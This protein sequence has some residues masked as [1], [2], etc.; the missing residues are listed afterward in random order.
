VRPRLA[1]IFAGL[2]LAP[3]SL[4]VWIG[5]DWAGRAREAARSRA[6]E[7]IEGR[8]DAAA[9]RVRGLL[10]ERERQILRAAEGLASGP[11]ALREWTR[12]TPAVSQVF[13]L[14][15][16]RKRIHPP[17]QGPANA[18]E[19][20]FLERAGQLWLDADLFF[21]RPEAA[22]A[23]VATPGVPPGDPGPAGSLGGSPAGSRGWY[24]W[25]FGSGL[26]L[27]F[28]ERR[29]SGQVVGFE[30]DRVRFLSDVAAR[31]PSEEGAP[32]SP[33]D[34]LI[35]LVAD[36]GETLCQWGGYQP[37]E[38]EPPVAS[39][40]LDRPLTSWRLD[41]LR[42]PAAG[43][44]LPVGLLRL[45]GGLGASAVLVAGLAAYF[46]RESSRDLREAVRRVSCV[47]QVS[48]ELKGPLT[49]IRLYGEILQERIP[50]TDEASSRSIGIIVSESQRLSR[51]I[52]NILTFAR[53]QQ[54]RLVLHRRSGVVD[55]VVR[56]AVARWTPALGA[57]G[58]EAAVEAGAPRTVSLD[59]DA[60]EGI[61]DN[62][63]GNAEKYAPGSGSLRVASEEEGR[64]TR[65]VI[66]DLGPGIPWGRREDVFRPFHRLDDRLTEGVSGAGLGLWIARELARLHG[67]DL[68]LLPS[69]RGA[70]FEV[71]LSTPEADP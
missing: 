38:G 11:E 5:I 16:D 14:G 44:A 70:R 47:N 52:H 6:R 51:L 57:K 30:L 34:A 41:Y 61:L 13:V 35:R 9:S 45:V 28:W 59:P 2:V 23:P 24:P 53:S 1:V 46:F 54:G 39:K 33:A 3:L 48:H 55:E 67:G 31:L 10:E 15:P 50:A 64:L 21:R 32:G 19:L 60:L 29:E 25:F 17:P 40:N 69:E 71:T 56:A 27:V 22:P 4:L 68:R 65:I 37:G 20:A 43:E 42:D 7:L 62:L 26:C 63:L 66:A 36:R 49:N 12:T 18:S 8:L 58:I